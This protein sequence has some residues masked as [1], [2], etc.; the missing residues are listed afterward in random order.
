M[1]LPLVG[2]FGRVGVIGAEE[3]DRLNEGLVGVV[4]GPLFYGYEVQLASRVGKMAG[5]TAEALSKLSECHR[6]RGGRAIWQSWAGGF[7]ALPPYEH[8]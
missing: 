3:E 2:P 8:S 6:A 1:L 7:L 5:V 4:F